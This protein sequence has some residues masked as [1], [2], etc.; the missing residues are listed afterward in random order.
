MLHAANLLKDKGSDLMAT[1]TITKV[2][3]PL[4]DLL[5]YQLASHYAQRFVS[6]RSATIEGGELGAFRKTKSC[7]QPGWI[8]RAAPPTGIFALAI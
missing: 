6:C 1:K 4:A 7:G 8:L 3:G 5:R 2:T